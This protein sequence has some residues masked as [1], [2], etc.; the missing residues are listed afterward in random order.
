MLF[1]SASVEWNVLVQNDCR[2]QAWLSNDYLPEV[3][4][5][6]DEENFKCIEEEFFSLK[7][8]FLV[9][10]WNFAENANNLYRI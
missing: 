8:H 9:K 10:K 2:F 6:M 1:C 3:K 5:N 7:A 4:K